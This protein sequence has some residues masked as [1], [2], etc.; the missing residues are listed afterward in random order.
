MKTEIEDLTGRMFNGI[1]VLQYSHKVPHKN[2]KRYYHYWVCRC[3]CG[4]EFL[5]TSNVIRHEKYK[6]CGCQRNEN[7][8]KSMRVHGMSNSRLFRIWSGM[9]SRCASYGGYSKLGREV[10]PEWSSNNEK[11]FENFRDWAMANGYS[12][13][14]SIDRINNDG[15]YEPNNCRW[16]DR[17][18]QA[19]NTSRN[20]YYYYNGERKTLSELS[21]EYGI[22]RD[23]LKSRVFWG[24]ELDKAIKTPPKR[25]ARYSFNGKSHTL[26]E[27]ADIIGI[28]KQTLKDRL[29]R[30]YSFEDAVTGNMKVRKGKG[31]L[32]G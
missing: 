2:D 12:D 32:I 10:C 27:W 25:T 11:G 14:L 24:W 7:I 4:K 8:S 17:Y 1:E 31:V 20:H 22:P 5:C 18:T 28:P 26:R 23:L 21:R 19:N 16:A 3:H 9:N 30:G 13:D 29:H 15:N 6:S